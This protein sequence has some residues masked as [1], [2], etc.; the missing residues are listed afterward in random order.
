MEKKKQIPEEL[1]KKLSAAGKKGWEM[2]VKKAEEKLKVGQS[3]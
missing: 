3:K 1:R 2:K